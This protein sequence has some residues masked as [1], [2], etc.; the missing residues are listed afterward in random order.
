MLIFL[1]G[2]YK[3]NVAIRRLP[4]RD[5]KCATF[6]GTRFIDPI[7]VLACGLSSVFSALLLLSFAKEFFSWADA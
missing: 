7:F 1:V 2:S 3:P 6:N 5:R 4:S